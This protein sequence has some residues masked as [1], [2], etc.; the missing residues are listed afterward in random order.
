MITGPIAR[1]FLNPLITQEEISIPTH[2]PYYIILE[3]DILMSTL[4]SQSCIRWN[5]E[6]I[7]LNR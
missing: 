5:W 3:I 7:S 6:V 1:R 2:N 4:Q